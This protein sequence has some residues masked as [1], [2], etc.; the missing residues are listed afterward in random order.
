MC[1][2]SLDGQTNRIEVEKQIKGVKVE[3]KGEHGQEERKGDKLS[4]RG[5]GIRE[6]KGVKGG[7]V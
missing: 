7:G 2:C 5:G 4:G 3:R 6:I 1:N